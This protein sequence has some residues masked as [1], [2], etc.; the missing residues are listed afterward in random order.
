MAK[1]YVKKSD[2]TYVPQKLQSVTNIDVVQTTGD[3]QDKAMS[4]KA[5]TDAL[6]ALQEKHS[7]L[8][9]GVDATK[10]LS[11]YQLHKG[12]LN[13][14]SLVNLNG[15]YY[16]I[17]PIS[18]ETLTIRNQNYTYLYLTK[19]IPTYG[20]AIDWADTYTQR[21]SIASGTTTLNIHDAKYCILQVVNPDGNIAP[22][23]MVLDK[24]ELATGFREKIAELYDSKQDKLQVGVNFDNAPIEGS[25]NPITSGSV[26]TIDKRVGDADFGTKSVP[27]T[28]KSFVVGD[29]VNTF[30]AGQTIALL[31]DVPNWATAIFDVV[32]NLSY[33][34]RAYRTS[35]TQNYYFT[36]VDS[37]DKVIYKVPL[38]SGGQGWFEV[39]LVAPASATEVYISSYTMFSS[40]ITAIQML[41]INVTEAIKGLQ[42]FDAKVSINQWAGKTILFYGDSVTYLGQSVDGGAVMSGEAT[43]PYDIPENSYNWQK[44]V[45]QFLKIGKFY[46]RGIGGATWE[47][48]NNVSYINTETGA[49]IGNGTAIGGV[50]IQNN[51][52]AFDDYE[53]APEIAGCTRVHSGLSDWDRIE[54]SIPTSIANDIDAVFM[55]CHNSSV[56]DLVV[57]YLSSNVPDVAWT[58][59][60]SNPFGGDY[61]TNDSANAIIS[62]IQKFHARCPNAVI[63]VGTP[64]SGQGAN[65][66]SSTINLNSDLSGY[67]RAFNTK[68]CASVMSS[69]CIDVFGT[70]G[71]NSTNR[72]EYISDMVHPFKYKGGIATARA[73]IGGL[74]GIV[75]SSLL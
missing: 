2:G 66:G 3:S 15:Y 35:S 32:G 25:L 14:S 54:A 72:N 9:I 68:K 42:G 39:E 44:Y 45:C 57:N 65:D 33:K 4:Q 16:I 30:S 7:E 74:I 43:Y 10:P 49:L 11:E 61:D 71:I 17:I 1:L 53:H 29:R 47:H 41:P 20:S 36:F 12:F 67:T 21:S 50:T 73:I 26:S 58:N 8:E 23:S 34:L 22:Y 75:P 70:D 18:G 27:L 63:I 51:T 6:T 52:Y 19:S 31:H 24:Y 60:P 62:T 48:M 38:P 37:N 64:I 28:P 56:G 46:T 55:F 69:P 13:V 59:S 5:V 40:A